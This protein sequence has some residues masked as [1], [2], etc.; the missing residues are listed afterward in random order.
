VVVVN[1]LT[2]DKGAARI[3]AKPED[4]VPLFPMAAKDEEGVR[5]IARA[6]MFVMRTLQSQDH[7]SDLIPPP[8]GEGW[9]KPAKYTVAKGEA[10]WKVAGL[11]ILWD[12]A[13]YT[14]ELEFDKDRKLRSAKAIDTGAR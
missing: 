5:E 11:D 13:F 4:A 8:D 3:L 1:D 12:R 6:Y 14:F 2:D 9:R 7:V 10:G